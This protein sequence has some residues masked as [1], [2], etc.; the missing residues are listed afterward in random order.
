MFIIRVNK[1][2]RNNLNQYLNQKKIQTNL[3]YIPIYRH[4]FYKKF[5]KKKLFP[6]SEKYYGEAITIPLHT[7][8]N[9]NQLTYIIKNIKYFF[10]KK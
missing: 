6:N 9:K 10:K 5:F 2:I 4:A 3:H 1:K 8:L 7:K